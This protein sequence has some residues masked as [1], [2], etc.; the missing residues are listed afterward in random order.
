MPIAFK[1]QWTMLCGLACLVMAF[2]TVDVCADD[3]SGDRAASGIRQQVQRLIELLGHPSYAQ[4]SRARSELERMGLVAFDAL[5]AAQMHDDSEIA[6]QARYLVESLHV[7]WST[8]DDSVDVQEILA[9]YGNQSEVERTSRMDRLAAL[10]NREGLAALCRLVRFETKLRLSRSAALLIMQQDVDESIEVRRRNSTVIEESLGSNG[11]EAARWLNVYSRDLRNDTYDTKAWREIINAERERVAGH[12]TKSTDDLAVLDLYRICAVRAKYARLNDESLE[13]AFESLELVDGRKQPL[14]NATEWALGY[15]IWPVVLALFEREPNDFKK[16]AWLLYAVAEAMTETGQAAIG[17]QLVVDALELSPLKPLNADGTSSMSIDQREQMISQHMLVAVELVQRG[18]FK[19]AEREYRYIINRN[20]VDSA[21]ACRARL[22]LA[23]ML[24]ESLRYGDASNVLR[25]AVDR[26]MIDSDFRRQVEQE[27]RP[28]ETFESNMHY[29]QGMAYVAAN[30]VEK[31]R[32]A[33][34]SALRA[35]QLHGDILIAMYRLPGDKSWDLEV[36]K[37]L[38]NASAEFANNIKNYERIVVNAGG[39]QKQL[40]DLISFY[41]NQYA[42]LIA[43]TK[44]DFHRALAFSQRSVELKPNASSLVDT[45]AHCYFAVGDVNAAVRTQRLALS[46]DPHSLPIKR[47]LA[48]FESKQEES[49]DATPA[50][51][52]KPKFRSPKKTAQP[53]P[54]KRSVPS[55]ASPSL[56]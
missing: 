33:F 22:W 32:G 21:S 2:G 18:R 8:D 51:I 28:L 45:L 39:A 52:L 11:R 44:G 20:P 5:H 10:P 48:F 3:Q 54:K 47:Q 6:M 12:T 13:L 15:E 40:A 35:D 37:A 49:G 1:F 19:W 50:P 38:R 27:V 25:P 7:S 34:R 46:L 42:W 53:A 29:Y 23:S 31:A 14:R 26:M 41:C 4:R 24:S 36:D 17:E 30:D 43:N 56:Q 9:D 55:P 16:D